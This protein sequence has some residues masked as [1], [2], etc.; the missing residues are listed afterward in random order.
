MLVVTLTAMMIQKNNGFEFNT[1]SLMRSQ[2]DRDEY[3]VLSFDGNLPIKNF[4][5]W[6]SEVEHFFD[7]VEILSGKMVQL[8]ANKLKSDAGVGWDQINN[9]GPDKARNSAILNE[10]EEVAFD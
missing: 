9:Q 4:A 10:D 7:I 6:L 1:Y 3:S 2:G 5:N 8:V